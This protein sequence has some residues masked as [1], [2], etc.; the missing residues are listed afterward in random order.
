MEDT[1]IGLCDGDDPHVVR[2]DWFLPGGLYALM[3]T[4]DGVDLGVWTEVDR[5]WSASCGDG[6]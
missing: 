2:E 5:W 3:S 6:G 1:Y 4:L